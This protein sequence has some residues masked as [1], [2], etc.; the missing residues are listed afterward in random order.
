MDLTLREGIHLQEAI[1]T[2]KEIVQKSK[3]VGFNQQA[4]YQMARQDYGN[5]RLEV[6][7]EEEL[8]FVEEFYTDEVIRSEEIQ[9][10]SKTN[11]KPQFNQREGFVQEIQQALQGSVRAVN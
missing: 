1:Q 7:V 3:Q 11:A 5:A 10:E 6:N 9:S 2:A 4:L 8:D